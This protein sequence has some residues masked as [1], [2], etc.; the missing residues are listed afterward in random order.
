[1][2][3]TPERSRVGL[4]PLFDPSTVAVV[5]ASRDP[6]K[7]GSQI[8]AALLDGG[9]TGTIYPVN[10]RG[11]EVCGLTCHT[12]L[13]DVP[14]PVDVVIVA[15][16]PAA[17]Q[18]AVELAA[19]REDA[20]V[21]VY[22]A[23]FAETGDDGVAAQSALT[24]S[25][26]SSKAR[27]LGPNCMGIFN[28]SA[29]VNLTG[30][31]GIGAGEIGII[32]QSGNVALSLIADSWHYGVGFSKF[33]SIGNQA[34]I[35][36]ADALENYASDLNTHVIMLY[37]ESIP[38]GGGREFMTA[39]RDA[40]ARKPVVVLKGG[41]TA[42]GSRASQSH[43]AGLA[44]DARVFS[45]AIR[46]TG[47]IEV[48]WLEDFLP[49]AEA[50]LRCPPLQGANIAVVGSGGGHSILC[51]DA[52]EKAGLAVRGFSSSLQ[53]EIAHRLPAWAPTGNP[54]DMTGA[55]EEDLY[56]FE[57]LASLALDD[58]SQRYDGVL[59]YGLY[60]YW[61]GPD[62]TDVR[63]V[64]FAEAAEMFGR[65]QTR[66]GR[67]AILYSPYARQGFES[68]RRVRASGV[69]CFDSLRA[70]A[71]SFAALRGRAQTARRRALPPAQAS[72]RCHDHE[73][74]ITRAA[75]R[76]AR[77]L[78]EIEA[79]EL[80]A[81]HGIP[82]V[83]HRVCRDESALRRAGR[84]VGFPVVLKV[85]STVMLHKSDVGGVA[86]GIHDE[87][88]L[89]AAAATIR[90]NVERQQ[91]GARISGYLVAAELSTEVELL[92][93]MVRDPAF[94]PVVAVAAGGTLT[95]ALDDA[96]F[97]VPPFDAEDVSEAVGSLRIAAHLAG[98]RGVRPVDIGQLTTIAA[99]V[100]ELGERHPEIE[101]I[102]LNPVL[103]S[104][105]G[106]VCVD[107]RVILEEGDH[108]RA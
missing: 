90:S 19:E 56:S 35:T 54:V 68:L 98:A 17:A 81:E 79:Y 52:V 21:I 58:E 93:G 89:V 55:F 59:F 23:G 47:A 69:P 34:D 87:A 31:K 94:G 61:N 38:Q 46:Q 13:A 63:G 9:Y 3:L 71:S 75:S 29:G 105:D 86:L 10:R 106:L 57:Q 108:S 6:R 30:H 70:V 53:A 76:P 83:P 14:R 33:I 103:M 100:A 12:G 39:L 24:A 97:L 50:L 73:T 84:E 102:D 77:N 15:L 66:F 60:G 27:M 101:E 67:P 26:R 49:V 45:A 11:G 65:V 43:T 107:A 95:N 18:E 37:L 4:D 25:L 8:V 22:S 91:P 85:V 48:E 16:A 28:T 72:K 96:A 32:S 62:W 5:G 88:E 36:A 42:S 40:A 99:S 1:M 80:S 51:A 20:F 78:T 104:D 74:L 82:V 64:S 41:T 7:T 92:I 44:G 2:A